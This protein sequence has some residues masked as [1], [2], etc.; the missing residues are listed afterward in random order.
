M[1]KL[2]RFI[3]NIHIKLQNHN[4]SQ[5]KTC[6]GQ[7]MFLFIKNEVGYN[8]FSEQFNLI[9]EAHYYISSIQI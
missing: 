2:V 7:S 8:S 3:E 1:Y 4:D 6:N 5:M 9:S